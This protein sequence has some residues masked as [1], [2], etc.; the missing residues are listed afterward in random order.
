[1]T[2]YPLRFR[3][4]AICLSALAGFVDAI[5]F[6]ALGGYFVSFMSGNSTRLGVDLAAG[7]PSAWLPAL[8]ILAFVAGAA[9]GAAI[10]AKAGPRRKAVVLALV[11]LL[12]A[13]GAAGAQAGAIPIAM[14]L[15]AAAMGASNSV[16]QREGEVAIGVTYMTGAL[17]K[18]GQRIAGAMLGGPRWAWLPHALLWSGL[19]AGALLGA[20]AH[21]AFGLAALWLA[22]AVA[23]ALTLAA[24]L[25][26][27]ADRHRGPDAPTP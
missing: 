15:A 5:G 10:A 8:I 21:A 11:T 20:L 9:A 18:L 27:P 19:A 1:M 23:A 13:G 25:M 2:G 12:L 17:V 24:L 22:A 3:L 14:I 26:G 4:L 6:L 16:F 7:V